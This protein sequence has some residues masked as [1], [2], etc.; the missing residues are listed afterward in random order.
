MSASSAVTVFDTLGALD[1]MEGIGL[2]VHPERCVRVRNRHASCSRC[3]DAC[4]SGAIALDAGALSVKP[5]L[6]VGCGTCAT[7]CPT[8]ALETRHP[9]DAAILAQ[10]KDRATVRF[11]CHRAAMPCAVELLCLSRLEESLVFELFSR[12]VQR[13]ECFHGNCDACP[14]KTGRESALLVKKTCETLIG[15]WGLDCT[16]EYRAAK[17]LGEP[18]DFSANAERPKTVSASS[19]E[20]PAS[21]E[22]PACPEAPAC[23]DPSASPEPPASRVTHVMADGTLPH[24]VPARRG[25]LLDALARLGEP[26]EGE[27]DTRLWGHV[28][29]DM[30]LCRSCRMCAVFCP[31]GAI[32]KFADEQGRVGIEHYQ[33]ECVHCGLCQDICPARAMRCSTR[34]IVRDLACGKTERYPM[35]A[36]AWTLGPD[37]IL[38]RMRPQITGNSVRHSYG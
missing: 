33:A 8:C 5:G 38:R 34:V 16:I 18:R 13:I 20:A 28:T 9:N 23:L 2:A 37:Q 30:N 32:T 10:A 14:R 26:R 25:R 22:P 15:A 36:P 21:P 24:F 17:D 29:I 6:C 35:S 11:A 27:I 1:A 7:V 4:T 3:S 19:S 31:T 12:G